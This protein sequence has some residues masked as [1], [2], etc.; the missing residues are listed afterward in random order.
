MRLTKDS[1]ILKVVVVSPFRTTFPWTSIIDTMYFYSYLLVK[2]G[3]HNP[4]PISGNIANRIS[5]TIIRKIANFQK[6]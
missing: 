4:G 5:I 2:E 1:A 3:F 6:E